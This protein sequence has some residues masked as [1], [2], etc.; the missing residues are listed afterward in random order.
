MTSRRM[1]SS[2]RSG[3]GRGRPQGAAKE[4]RAGERRLRRW[5]SSGRSRRRF[6][7]SHR[8]GG[9]SRERHLGGSKTGG[10][11]CQPLERVDC[12]PVGTLFFVL[13]FVGLG[14]A[15]LVIAMSRGRGGL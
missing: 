5:A 11:A 12:R 2:W 4:P 1:W 9:G 15:T 7:A 6:R 3:G 8:G 10:A 13:V 14:L